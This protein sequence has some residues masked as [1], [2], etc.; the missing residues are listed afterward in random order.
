MKRIV[1]ATLITLALVACT[2]TS[3]PPTPTR[4]SASVKPEI[5][6]GTQVSTKPTPMA[7]P[8]EVVIQDDFGGTPHDPACTEDHFGVGVGLLESR[9]V[10]AGIAELERGV[11]DE[12]E[13]FDMRKSLGEAYLA[14]GET[15]KAVGHL[16]VAVDQVDD[17]D[18]WM[19]L[20]NACFDRKDFDEAQKA[21]VKVAKLDPS[22]PEPWKLLARVFQSKSM[23]KESIDASEEAIARGSDSPWTFNN[24]GYAY[25]VLGKSDDAVRELEKAVSFDSGVTSPIWNNLGLAYEKQGELADAASAY[26]AALAGNPGYVKAKVNL[27]RLTEVAK[28]QG[29][30]IGQR[31][32]EIDPMPTATPAEIEDRA[33]GE[34]D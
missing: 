26:R 12:P 16:R 32:A 21:I 25:L 33:I 7:T 29:I 13:N 20:A 9:Q 27:S 19:E 5:A 6:T 14:Q 18:T 28:A 17:A 10:E 24:L 15:E 3:N 11:Y 8:M 1:F 23:W 31:K 34:K 22:S 4:G 2:R 30:A